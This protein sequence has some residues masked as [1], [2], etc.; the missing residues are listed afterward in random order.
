MY[1]TESTIALK[2]AMPSE[3]VFEADA[4]GVNV[5]GSNGVFGVLPGHAKLISS[6]KVGVV[7]VFTSG[8]E[9]KFFIYGGIVEV[10]NFETNIVSEFAVNLEEQKRSDLLDKIANLKL[11]LQS[12]VENS[13]KS[14]ILNDSIIKYSSLLNFVV[15]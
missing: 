12:S 1:N 5:P 4:T 2:I 9:K 6:I 3:V 10:N 14:K 7:S 15:Q 8:V 11:E 13:L